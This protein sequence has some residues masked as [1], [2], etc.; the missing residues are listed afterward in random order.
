MR[1]QLGTSEEMEE[2]ARQDGPDVKWDKPEAFLKMIMAIP[3]IHSRR[4]RSE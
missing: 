2:I 1:A 4:S 3:R